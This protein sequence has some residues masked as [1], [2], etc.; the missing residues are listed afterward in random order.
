VVIEV[1][2]DV[3]CPWCYVGSRN[4][5]EAL[6]RFPHADEVSVVWRSYELDPNGPRERDGSYVERIARKYGV[7]VGQARASMSRIISVGAEAGID[8]RFDDA[9]LGNTFD[10][11]R[12]LHLARANGRQEALK[13]R[14]FL[15]AFTEGR[16]IGDPDTLVELAVDAGLDEA[17]ARRVLDGDEHA[18]DVR[19]DEAAARQL[20][21]QGVP[22]F[23]ID[24]RAVIPGAQPVETMLAVIQRAWDRRERVPT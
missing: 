17:D 11:H 20:D 23:L 24:G 12:L 14:L 19:A 7:P 2:S 21:V 15:A 10:A 9:R 22:H 5:G 6:R 4:L 8:F 1:W 18:E 3:V 13:D 16:A